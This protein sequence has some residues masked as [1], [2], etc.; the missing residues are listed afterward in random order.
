[1]PEYNFS[2]SDSKPLI[3]IPLSHNT[4]KVTNRLQIQ[5]KLEKFEPLFS[6]LRDFQDS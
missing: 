3:L 6:G 1:M 4:S 5:K 2:G